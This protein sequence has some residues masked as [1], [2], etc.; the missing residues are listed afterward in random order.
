MRSN[1]LHPASLPTR[2]TLLLCASLTLLSGALVAP[3]LPGLRSA[4]SAT[5]GID[6]FAPLSLSLPALGVVLSGAAAG[7]LAD[8][9]GRKP[10]LLTSLVLYAAAGASG[11]ITSSVGALLLGRLLLGVAIAGITVAVS[12]LIADYYAGD[13]RAR[14]TGLQ[15]AFAEFG[16]VILLPLAGLLAGLSWRAPFLLYLVALPLLALAW[17]ALPNPQ[18][19]PPQPQSQSSGDPVPRLVVPIY[20]FGVIAMIAFNLIPTQLPF[21]LAAAGLSAVQA[22]LLLAANT[23]SAALAALT[24][25]RVRRHLGFVTLTGVALVALGS[26]TALIVA[27]TQVAWMTLGLSVAGAGLGLLLP[28]LTLW[29]TA[30]CSPSQ[31]ARALGGLV[32]ALFLGQVASPVLAQPLIDRWQIV[33]AFSAIG[34]A[35]VLLGTSLLALRAIARPA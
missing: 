25:S 35:V 31:R 8:R 29:V 22:S 19:T 10:L 1:E 13:Q 2:L 32:T 6:L 18:R 16:G 28:N 33:G 24:Y 23:L 20:A 4:F 3:A 15:N 5:P 21:Y 27:S 11:A 17:A 9:W 34:V 7:V 26:G 14:V 30:L 12:V